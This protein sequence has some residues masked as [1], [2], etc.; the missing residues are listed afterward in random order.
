[1]K[2]KSKIIA[3]TL[4]MG[5]IDDKRKVVIPFCYDKIEYIE[6]VSIE[7]FP[8]NVQVERGFYLCTKGNKHAIY[9][10]SGKEIISL[11][12]GYW[13]ESVLNYE[14]DEN[15]NEDF[16][17][18]AYKDGKVGI[19]NL[20]YKSEKSYPIENEENART[21]T[22]SYSIAYDFGKVDQIDNSYGSIKLRKTASR[23]DTPV[24]PLTGYF[25][26]NSTHTVVEPCFA[27]NRLEIELN[28]LLTKYEQS[29]QADV[30][31]YYSL[32]PGR[33]TE[34]RY[35][36]LQKA[37]GEYIELFKPEY[38][39]ISFDYNLEAFIVSKDGP[40][41]ENP[42][43]F[44]I[45]VAYNK[46][47]LQPYFKP[48]YEL[49]L[50]T[51]IEKPSKN[52]YSFIKFFKD[53][54]WGL[55]HAKTSIGVED[56][57]ALECCRFTKGKDYNYETVLPCEY[58][59][60]ECI[61]GASTFI[62]KKDGFKELVTAE[63]FNNKKT[64]NRIIRYEGKYKDISIVAKDYYKCVKENG[65]TD[66]IKLEEQ[67]IKF[68][69]NIKTG[70]IVEDA[71]EIYVLENKGT[72]IVKAIK[73]GVTTIYDLSH[74]DVFKNI[75]DVSYDDNKESILLHHKSG[76]IIARSLKHNNFVMFPIP[77]KNYKSIVV[78]YY[79]KIGVGRVTID[80]ETKVYYLNNINNHLLDH[81]IITKFD[82]VGG[83]DGTRCVYTEII[84][85]DKITKV[86][87]IIAQESNSS[88]E[89]AGT[90]KKKKVMV[91]SPVSTPGVY[92]IEEFVDNATRCIISH[93]GIVSQR[94]KYNVLDTISGELFFM[95]SYDHISYANDRF[96]CTK[97]YSYYYYDKDG[98]EIVRGFAPE[99]INNGTYLRDRKKVDN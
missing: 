73:D 87:D 74:G 70:I 27:L 75:T 14:K 13:F 40:L 4:K 89:D 6:L 35:G 17:I 8:F 71:D 9:D 21:Y 16:Y 39:S 37:D 95:D 62:A 81:K 85:G 66:I 83:N 86:S 93:F 46:K 82:V 25:H 50:G 24:I 49:E 84:D 1:M 30:L 76:C 20:S 91:E 98:F 55:I 33:E 60:I 31:I 22:S 34:Y 23:K 36:A 99:D 59:S 15:L 63:S 58:D 61:D 18:K 97:D 72:V 53:E 90:S 64:K 3:G 94:K 44:L 77:L 78:D 10:F 5:T 42:T 68:G 79:T 88:E 52:D 26:Y 38:G 92:E 48:I 47:G 96:V 2:I 29:E 32:L 19:I 7:G 28:S 56:E 54:K 43:L 12:D 41:S 45:G 67:I 69:S 51:K 80:G 57:D 65:K 11:E